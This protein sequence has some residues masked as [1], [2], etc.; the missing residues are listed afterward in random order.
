MC[1]PMGLPSAPDWPM[2]LDR[3]PAGC[4]TRSM[5]GI[6]AWM[7]TG[8]AEAVAEPG[9]NS[10]F[11]RAF[12]GVHPRQSSEGRRTPN[13]RDERLMRRGDGVTT[14]ALA[15]KAGCLQRYRRLGDTSPSPPLECVILASR[16]PA[17]CALRHRARA[18][19]FATAR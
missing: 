7:I 5:L 2:Q 8:D 1:L 11:D 10:A 14:P 17:V 12:A 18:R 3:V 13:T 15:A 19:A 4:S 16:R 6:Q 9:A